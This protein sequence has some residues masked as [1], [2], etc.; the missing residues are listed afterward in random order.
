[1]AISIS[2]RT[3]RSR[4]RIACSCSPSRFINVSSK[5]RAAR[6]RSRMR[7]WVLSSRLP[8]S[9]SLPRPF[10]GRRLL[11]FRDAQD[12]HILLTGPVAKPDVAL[13]LPSGG[14]APFID[15][16]CRQP[17]V[18]HGGAAREATEP[19]PLGQLLGRWPL[20]SPPRRRNLPTF[21]G[22]PG[23]EPFRTADQLH[24]P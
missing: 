22:Q 24:H 1:M 6:P 19:G 10:D 12:L 21:L 5:A 14:L 18:I 16:P 23:G 9:T 8:M 17:P 11:A 15:Y 7:R 2:R 3:Q 13:F 20:A 4:M